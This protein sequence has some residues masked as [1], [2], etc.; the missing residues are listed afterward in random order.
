MAS[1]PK[2][3]SR[4]VHSVQLCAKYRQESVTSTDY[5][6]L[7]HEGPKWSNGLIKNN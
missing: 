1:L 3:K 4:G 5:D 7:S 2:G 6:S